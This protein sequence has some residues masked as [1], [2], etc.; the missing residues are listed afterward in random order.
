MNILDSVRIIYGNIVRWLTVPQSAPEINRK[1]FINVQIDAIGV[2]LASTAAP[3][4]PVFLTR[5][6]ASTL[7]IS[8]LTFMPAV[9]G[10]I[11]AIPL[12]QFLQ[13]RRSVIPFFS[14]AR[15]GVLSSYALTGLITLLLPREL[16]VYGILAI[17]AVA[18]IPQTVLNITFSV[19]MN[20]VAGPAGRLN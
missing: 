1:N 8:A 3:F 6:E 16:S 15:L 7:A 18:T 10:M 4:L 12:G 2:G 9:T 11:L 5:L 17:W 19:V 13:T 20:S 14:M